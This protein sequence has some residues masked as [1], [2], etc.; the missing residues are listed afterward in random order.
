METDKNVLTITLGEALG[1]LPLQG[2]R[3]GGQGGASEA[4]GG[5]L[6][7]LVGPG[8]ARQAPVRVEVVAGA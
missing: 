7:R 4:L 1:A 2:A 6:Q 3:R 5:G 8:R